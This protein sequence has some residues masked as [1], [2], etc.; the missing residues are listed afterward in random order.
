MRT[1]S[2]IADEIRAKRDAVKRELADISPY[3]FTD[4]RHLDANTPERA[5]WH[6]G[7]C[8]AL[9]DVLR[10]LNGDVSQSPG[11]ADTSS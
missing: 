9:S 2:S 11:S 3:A 6:L 1:S 10:R 7:Y 4:Q 5:Y 8:A